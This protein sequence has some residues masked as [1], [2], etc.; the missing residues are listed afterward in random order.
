[1]TIAILSGGP[2]D[3][4]SVPR[5]LLWKSNKSMSRVS[6]VLPVFNAA[7]T[8]PACVNSILAQTLNDWEL[9]A[10]DD[11]STDGSTE[12]LKELQRC[13]ER[14]RVLSP[15]RIGLVAAINL[16]HA[17]ATTELI[18]RMDADDIMHPDRLRKQSAYL[19]SHSGIA[20]L[21]TRVRLFPDEAVEAGYRE[22]VRWQNECLTPEQI[23][24]NIYVE[25]PLANPSVMW[26]RS[27][28]ER[29]GPYRN[30]A[31]PE[32]YE[33]WLRLHAA[34][35]R[36][37]KLPEILLDW[38]ESPNRATR[39]DPRFSRDAFNH[40]RAEYLARDERLRSG[41][42]IV[43]WGAGRVTRQ[44]VRLI[45]ER[46]VT[47]S[48]YVDIDPRKIG[49]SIDRAAVHA[50]EWLQQPVKPFVLV[51]VTNHGARDQIRRK[52]EQMEYRIADDFLCV[53]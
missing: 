4:T 46:G 8:L 10:V 53:G 14:I 40:I 16:G 13:D 49:G 34:G 20:V 18:A 31:F 45:E 32:D 47:I 3:A 6:I 23:A 1:M 29:F 30:G 52:L 22:Y 2:Q 24:G 48:A 51:Y 41:R 17:A 33:F 35:I 38:R 15:G 5:E 36:M 44:R 26:R 39:N 21:A 28:F 42:D 27:V 11:G 12:A 25:S 19:K 43:V 50:P 9:I 7:T 37:A